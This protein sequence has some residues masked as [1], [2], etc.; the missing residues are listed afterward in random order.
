MGNVRWNYWSLNEYLRQFPQSHDEHKTQTV[1]NMASVISFG[2]QNRGKYFD[3]VTYST[4]LHSTK[5]RFDELTIRRKLSTQCR[6]RRSA[7]RRSVIDPTKDPMDKTFFAGWTKDPTLL[8]LGGQNIPHWFDGVDK[9]SYTDFSPWTKHPILVNL[10]RRSHF[11]LKS[12]KS[13]YKYLTILFLVFYFVLNSY[14][15]L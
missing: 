13:A 7:V 3:K 14:L 1:S 15:S 6:S 9:R 4:K 10:D 2:I 8:H 11:L 5:W 12:H